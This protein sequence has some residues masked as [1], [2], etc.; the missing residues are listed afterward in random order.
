[1]RLREHR[2]A[3]RAERLFS[4]AEDKVNSPTPWQNSRWIDVSV[5]LSAN[6]P[7]WPGAPAFEMRQDKIPLGKQHLVT[8][9]HLKLI[10]HCGT[11]IDAPLHFNRHGASIDQASLSLLMGPCRVF[12]HKPS[13][14]ITKADLLALGEDVPPRVLFKTANSRRLQTGK[15]DKHFIS[16]LP[17][18]IEEL[19]ARGVR[20]L[21]VDGF[22]IGPYGSMS[23]RNHVRYCGQG[24]LIIEVMNLTA[25]KPGDYF[26]VA[27]P[28]KIRRAEAAPARVLLFKPNKASAPIHSKLDCI[29]SKT[30]KCKKGN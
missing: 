7:V 22:S 18:A 29:S 20:V 13:R 11:H 5:P 12:E 3:R 1:M 10:V 6:V 14:H 16:L 28:L 15:L 9:S 21:G 27:L 26:L 25:V 19:L 8:V 17:D 2:P 30:N 24:G 4:R 23:D